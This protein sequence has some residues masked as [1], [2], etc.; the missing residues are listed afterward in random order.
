MKGVVQACMVCQQANTE[1]VKSPGLLQPLPVPAESWQII[2]MDFIEGLPQYGFANCIFVVVD[3][4]TKF[5]HFIALKHPYTTASVAKV[6]MDQV[7][8]LH[9]LPASIVSSRDPIFKSSFWKELFSL[10]HVQLRMNTSYH[11][12][13]DG[14][15]E[16]VNQCLETFLRCFVS[17]K[18]HLGPYLI[19]VIE[20]NQNK[21]L[22]V[23]M[24]IKQEFSQS[25]RRK[26][27]QRPPNSCQSKWRIF[28]G[29]SRGFQ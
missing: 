14:Q 28:E 19:S 17:V 26:G 9:G 20:N 3:K 29:V 27:K 21:N 2:T 25:K 11:P 15:T 12:Q 8:K 10:T 4:F 7:Y 5:A 24:S 18:V 23:S 16:R 22:I 6:F 13:S 1:R